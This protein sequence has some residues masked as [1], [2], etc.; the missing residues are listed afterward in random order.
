MTIPTGVCG[1]L[2][3]T[4]QYYTE[5]CYTKKCF[6]AYERSL[7]LLNYNDDYECPGGY[8][9]L[10]ITDDGVKQEAKKFQRGI[11]VCSVQHFV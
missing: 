4:N 7:N 11:F 2:Y 9:M 5:A 8:E 10:R 6:K 3:A 1:G